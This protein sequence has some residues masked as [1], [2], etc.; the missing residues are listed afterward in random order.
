M[1]N[2]FSRFGWVYTLKNKSAATV[3]AAFQDIYKRKFR[4]FR[5]IRTNDGKQFKGFVK[6]FSEDHNIHQIIA[7]GRNK[8]ASVKR[9]EKTS[10]TR[11]FK[12]F[13]QK[14][15]R[16]LEI[17]LD[18]VATHNSQFRR[19]TGLTLAKISF[20]N[21]QELIE[22][23]RGANPSQIPKPRFHEGDSVRLLEPFDISTKLYV[24]TYCEEIYVVEEVVYDTVITYELHKK[25]RKFYA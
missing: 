18:I 6:F 9:F 8:A 3:E 4:F 10:K 20:R 14:R 7:R 22:R 16:W 21:Q 2:C 11:L 25:N 23:Q 17:L 5:Y 15:N 12:Y 1:I 19:S 24:Q 13:T